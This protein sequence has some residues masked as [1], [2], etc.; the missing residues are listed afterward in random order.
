MREKNLS[1]AG[2]SFL[3]LLISLAILAI[4]IGIP[5][6]IFVHEVKRTVKEV[7]ISKK[8]LED[9]PALEV[10]RKDIETAGFGLPWDLNGIL[11]SEATSLATGLYS[12][13]P[14]LFNDSPANAPRA[15]VGKRDKIGNQFSYLV[16]KGSILGLSKASNHWT[17]IDNNGDLNIW[18]SLTTANYN[19]LKQGDNVILLQAS[20]RSLVGGSMYFTITQDASSS[21]TNP[22]D[23][24]LPPLQSS[25]YLI[26][27]INNSITGSPTLRAPFNRVDYR[28][29]SQS[30][31]PSDCASGTYT[32]ARAIMRQTDGAIVSYPLLHC[33][34]DFQVYFELDTNGDG[35]IDKCT[36]DLTPFS[37]LQIRQE[38]KEVRVFLLVQNG[39]KDVNYNFPYST[40]FVGDNTTL[41]TPQNFNMTRIP[42][43]QHYRWKVLS[44]VA[45]PKD[46]E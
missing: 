30:N 12:F 25:V 44:V 9:I 46:L 24:G 34:A 37:A 29:Y 38:L 28:L 3:E 14:T 11:Y 18:P 15:I 22:L 5:L 23:Y 36:Q 6:K 17:Y 35:V 40:V 21:D 45:I 2:F 42:D 4:V 41:C 43:Y 16:L 27:G 20:D 7:G 13:A 8:T 10:I 26:Y 19:N 33:V 31:S 39:I 1:R 32:L